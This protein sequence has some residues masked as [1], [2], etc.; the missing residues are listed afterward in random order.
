MKIIVIGAGL[1]G[2]AAAFRLQQEGHEVTLLEATKRP[3]RRVS[4]F[5]E[6]GFLIDTGP[7][8]PSTRY[9][10]FSDLATR[11]VWATLLSVPVR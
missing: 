9:E 4:T 3:G 2:L 8:I 7:E 1:S 11:S 5:K 10:R 6:R